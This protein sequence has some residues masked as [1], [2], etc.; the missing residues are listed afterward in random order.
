MSVRCV[1]VLANGRQCKKWSLAGTDLCLMHSPDSEAKTRAK[2]K[3]RVG[4]PKNEPLPQPEA[5]ALMEEVAE[6]EAMLRPTLK[7]ADGRALPEYQELLRNYAEDRLE[8][9]E[10]RK[11]KPLTQAKQ[12]A[13]DSATKRRDA[14][15]DALGLGG[16]ATLRDF[17]S[18]EAQQRQARAKQG[19]RPVKSEERAMA[20][21]R[22]LQ[23]SHAIPT[24]P[25]LDEEPDTSPP[26][27]D[28]AKNGGT[29]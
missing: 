7:D 20:V 16:P 15:R 5:V 22:L 29:Q 1:Q 9:K 25:P 13:I 10:L 14:E 3:L 24:L 12:R 4:G 27:T 18:L 17:D 19:K 11:A 26:L 2:A 23:K 21:A 6:V 28:G 8:V